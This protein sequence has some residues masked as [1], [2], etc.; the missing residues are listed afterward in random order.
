MADKQVYIGNLKVMYGTGV[1][2]S[3][4]TNIKTT[5]TFDG[6][7]TDGTDNIPYSVTMDRLRYGT[8]T[9][10]IELDEKLDKM[11]T[12]PDTVK[13][14]EIVRTS[15]ESYKIVDYIYN[16]LVDDDSYEIKPDERTV[17][18]LGFKGSSKKRKYVKI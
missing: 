10:T 5:P 15:T 16:C 14:E 3:P 13:V 17:E 1:K 9:S 2:V 18:N 12:V 6:V 7:L 4:E 8:L 11:L